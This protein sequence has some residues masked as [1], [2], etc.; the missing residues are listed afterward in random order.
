MRSASR[1]VKIR[2]SQQLMRSGMSSKQRE[3]SLKIPRKASSGA[4]RNDFPPV[5]NR[6][7]HT[8]K[9]QCAY[10]APRGD[11]CGLRLLYR[12]PA[13]GTGLYGPCGLGAGVV[14]F[15][16]APS[17]EGET[18]GGYT[19]FPG[20]TDPLGAETDASVGQKAV[21]PAFSRGLEAG[22]RRRGGSFPRWKGQQSGSWRKYRV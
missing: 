3:L 10:P 21:C 2:I 17:S 6:K 12:Q 14:Q 18:T 22:R 1:P 13:C 15:C 8:K 16:F 7:R 9:P 19:Y 20:R 4:V 5:E 11:G